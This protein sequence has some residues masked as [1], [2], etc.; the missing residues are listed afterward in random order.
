MA[1]SHFGLAHFM[2]RATPEADFATNG[3]TPETYEADFAISGV[4]PETFILPFGTTDDRR[5]KNQGPRGT[6]F[7]FLH[8]RKRGAM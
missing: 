8:V 7:S 4:T 6:K 5:V 1:A 2:L 3:G